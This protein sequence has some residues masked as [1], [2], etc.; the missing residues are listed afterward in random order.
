MVYFLIDVHFFG[1]I[2]GGANMQHAVILNI[3]LGGMGLLFLCM[4]I[5]HFLRPPILMEADSL[6]IRIYV[7]YQKVNS[8]FLPWSLISGI[9]SGKM[10]WIG[11]N[12]CGATAED[13]DALL[14][15]C[16]PSIRLDDKQWGDGHVMNGFDNKFVLNAKY[17]PESLEKA[18]K[19]LME[20]KKLH[21]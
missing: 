3:F 18:A 2:P 8:L 12:D 15:A 21:S 7:R 11:F 10:R 9:T 4:G 16:D 1:Y 6:G 5:Y 20:M 19:R 14:V 13:A 17:L